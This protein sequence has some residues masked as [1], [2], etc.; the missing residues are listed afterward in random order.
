MTSLRTDAPP[1][2][3]GVVADVPQL[4]RNPF[5][6]GRSRSQKLLRAGIVGLVLVVL[7]AVVFHSWFTGAAIPPWDFLGSYN[8]D[9]YLWWT[10][11]GFFHPVDWVANVWA[12]Y[13]AALL[14]QNSAWYL[15]VG[16]VSAFVPFTLHASAALAALHVGF[17]AVGTYLLIRSFRMSFPIALVATVAAFFAVGYYSNA[18]HV[19]I[20]R[21]YA[22]VPWVLLILSPAWPW[23]KFWSI[24]L[25][26][27]LLWQALT[28]MYPGMVVTTVYAGVVWV[29]VYQVVTRAKL[30]AF[31][32]PAAISVVAA[33]LLS[34]P[35][36]VPYFLLP[37][38]AASG[39][40]ETSAFS[41]GEIGTLLF[42][43]SSDHL[44]NDISMRSFFVPA[45]VL[46]LALFARWRDPITKLATALA[47]P[48][49]LLG[50]PFFPW[51]SASQALPGLGLSRFTM[52]DF[53]V[54]LV[55]SAVLYASSGIRTL[56]HAGRARAVSWG[57]WA[58]LAAAFLFAAAMVVIGWKGPFASADWQPQAVVLALSLL[59]ILLWI[60]IRG[61]RL[62]R[63]ALPVVAG[64]LVVATAA[65]GLVWAFGTRAPWHA[66]RV[67][68][69]TAVW[70]ETVDQLI[71]RRVTDPSATQR[72]ARLAFP[73]GSSLADMYSVAWNRVYYTD[74]L[75]IGGYINLKGSKT[76]KLMQDA[77][78]DL[79]MGPALKGFLAAPG[80]L[81][82]HPTSTG[83][84]PS[85]LTQCTT[86]KAC[87]PATATPKSYEPGHFAYSISLDSPATAMLNESY[88]DGWAA[89]ACSDGRC[90]TLHPTR[91]ALGLIQVALPK[92]QYILEVDYQTQGRTLGWILFG[93]GVI[94]A[95][96][97][98]VIVFV[99]SRTS[100]HQ[101]G[102]R[103]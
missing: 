55:L 20:A 37:G 26:A 34:A 53:K 31:L 1:E 48:A 93:A 86:L 9:A 10:Q 76:Q 41:L 39:L 21:G 99:R 25:A 7:E 16:I 63:G 8:T 44:P 42:G 59:V 14:L 22:W 77:L 3:S 24:P 43:Y 87:G 27:F 96:A 18:E 58:S 54:F 45:A 67:A 50:M 30:W 35:R 82:S 94:I 85:E 2:T 28:G 90:T 52:S 57:I 49:F 91:S 17:G 38:D 13:P 36:L 4:S 40:G 92:G 98:G 11:G 69:E 64:V 83:F 33:G 84:S 80:T 81:I 5:A 78:L 79:Q 19:D 29:I 51:F 32:L 103:I 15:P 62:G 97:F 56:L 102:R 100:T 6:P 46:L 61:W 70:G 68:T 95:L 71:A 66:D 75:S 23:R 88:F 12:G 72:P 65:S 89:K 101:K 74:E 47:V 73:S 60:L